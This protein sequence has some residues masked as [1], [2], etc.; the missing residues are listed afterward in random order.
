MHDSH[1]DAL[2]QAGGCEVLNLFYTHTENEPEDDLRRTMT[3]MV[4]GR[5]GHILCTIS[6]VSVKQEDFIR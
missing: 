2:Q 3:H 4:K 1:S 5:T 6:G